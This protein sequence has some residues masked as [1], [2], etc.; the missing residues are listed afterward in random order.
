MRKQIGTPLLEFARIGD[1][2]DICCRLS[3]IGGAGPEPT[4]LHGNKSSRFRVRFTASVVLDA[5]K[6]NHTK[7]RHWRAHS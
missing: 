1:L 2:A 7:W 4:L 3:A 5:Q 6:P